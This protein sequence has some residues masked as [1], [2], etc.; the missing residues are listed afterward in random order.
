MPRTIVPPVVIGKTASENFDFE[1]HFAVTMLSMEIEM[2]D[3]S[4]IPA[5]RRWVNRLLS[6]LRSA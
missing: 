1:G 3:D 6:F 4:D 2:L 5:F